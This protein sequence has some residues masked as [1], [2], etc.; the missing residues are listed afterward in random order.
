MAVDHEATM[1]AFPV[2]FQ[3]AIVQIIEC[4]ERIIKLEALCCYNAF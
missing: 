4:S 1:L 3:R 2:F